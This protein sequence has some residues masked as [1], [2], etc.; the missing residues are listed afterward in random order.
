MKEQFNLDNKVRLVGNK[1]IVT[2]NH[3]NY[4]TFYYRKDMNSKYVISKEK[5]LAFIGKKYTMS[6]STSIDK[7]TPSL[8]GVPVPI[9]YDTLK[10][11]EQEAWKLEIKQYSNAE[12]LLHRNLSS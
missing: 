10:F 6:E 2:V 3:T 7:E 12:A 9:A 4:G 8:I 1:G 5:L 11:W